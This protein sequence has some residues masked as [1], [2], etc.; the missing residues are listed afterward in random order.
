MVKIL[1]VF[2]MLVSLS[3]CKLTVNSNEGGSFNLSPQGTDC[4]LNCYDY[5]EGTT[6]TITAVADPGFALENWSGACNGVSTS[7]TVTMSE[8]ISVNINFQSTAMAWGQ[9]AW[10]TN[11]WQ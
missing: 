8:D 2:A 6:V 7:C 5:D 11:T 10:S 1:L 3:A 9:G 4:G